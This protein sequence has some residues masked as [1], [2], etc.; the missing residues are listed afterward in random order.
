MP[1]GLFKQDDVRETAV[2]DT[3]KGSLQNFGS[4]VATAEFTTGSTGWTDVTNPSTFNIVTA[5]ECTVL[6]LA[7]IVCS[8]NTADRRNEFYL[9]IDGGYGNKAITEMNTANEPNTVFCMLTK[10]AVPAGTINIKLRMRVEGVSTGKIMY[11]A[12]SDG[13]KAK[14]VAFAF[15]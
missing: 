3:F 4:S 7:Q 1:G 15:I 10:T 5:Q 2:A 6:I 11:D 14:I 12:A 9:S 8:N 13:V